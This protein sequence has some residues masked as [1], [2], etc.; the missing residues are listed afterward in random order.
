MPLL[1]AAPLARRAA[2]DAGL[3]ENDRSAAAPIAPGNVRQEEACQHGT[4]SMV[5]AI[6][7]R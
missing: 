1:G 4:C 6:P 2:H 7:S 5:R 3:D